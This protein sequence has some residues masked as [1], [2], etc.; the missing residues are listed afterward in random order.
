M[1]CSPWGHKELHRTEQLNY[2]YI[3]IYIYIYK[4]NSVYILTDNMQYCLQC[5][6][7]W[8]SQVVLVVKNPPASVGDLRDSGL[9]PRL[10]ICPGEGNGNPLQ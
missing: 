10:G 5:V 3:Y 1:C 6:F 7:F 8:A 4:Y 9:I 2:T